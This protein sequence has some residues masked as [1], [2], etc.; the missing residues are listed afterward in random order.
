MTHHHESHRLSWLD[1]A[2]LIHATILLVFASWAYGGNIWWARLTLSIG[3]SLSLP[4]CLAAFLQGNSRGRHARRK[5]IWLLP[6]ALYAGLVVG[7]S[8]NP[9][10][11]NTLIDGTRLMAHK[12]APHPNWPSTVNSAQSLDSLWFGAGAY[13]TAFNIAV[14]IRSRRA[15]HYLLILI[16][17]NAL[18]LAVFGTLQA[19]SSAGFYL[20]EATSPNKR[21]FA[22][23]I[24][25][26]HWG[27]FMVLCLA[28]AAGLLFNQARKHQGVDL[29]QSPFTA[30]L[31]GFLLIAVT[32][33]ISASRAA[34]GMAA[35]IVAI[36]TVHAL[37][38]LARESRRAHQ[39]VWPAATLLL[40]VIAL[41]TAA[42]GWLGYRSIN[43]RYVETRQALE[44][45]QSIW[46]ERLDLYADT[47]ELARRQ[48]L[49]GWGL[50][51]YDVAFQLI[52]PRPL[53]A[54]RQYENSYATAHNDWLQSLA[55]TGLVGTI[56]LILTIALPL[57]R[58]NRRKLRHPLV[59]Y[60]LIG[61]TLVLLYA[62][63]EFPFSCGAFLIT[64]WILFFTALRKAELTLPTPPPRHE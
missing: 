42:A 53:Q 30:A 64:F 43:E 58:L 7:S 16:A 41:T 47:V 38:R 31:V 62:L 10:F 28:T 6:P 5:L 37:L 15:L 9:S 33:P 18:A 27:A 20:G 39:P 34:T 2:V 35:L 44:R 55:E 23:F 22:T 12:G 40:V 57:S 50:N 48:P 29:W 13:L 26:N 25:N 46:G 19:I 36:A 8:F 3:A 52:R 60:P 63:I 51:S 17:V 14:V 4:L 59:A 56:L 32:G 21:F 11:A 54:N 1:W 45:N 61:L 24:Y 49:F